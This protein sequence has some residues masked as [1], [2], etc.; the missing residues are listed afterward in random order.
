MSVQLTG[1]EEA[2]KM[3]KE[4]PDNMQR[5]ALRAAIYKASKKLLMLVQQTN[6]F[7]DKSGRLRKSIKISRKKPTRRMVGDDII[8][9]VPYAHL[10]E[11]GFMMKT[12]TGTKHVPG[13]RFLQGTL[14]EN[15]EQVLA[16]IE[17]ALKVYVQ[18]K[19]KKMASK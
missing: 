14:E 8:A 7:K 3:M 6:R 16:D 13:K 18:K 15:R 11:K 2:I 1:W 4:L 12:R 9:A 17:A 19:L 10:V 5:N